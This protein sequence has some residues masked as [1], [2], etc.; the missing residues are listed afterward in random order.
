MALALGPS[1]EAA[2]S[3]SR[4]VDCRRTGII[5]HNGPDGS[6]SKTQHFSGGR[7]LKVLLAAL[8]ENQIFNHIETRH[9]VRLPKRMHTCVI[10]RNSTLEPDWSLNDSHHEAM[11]ST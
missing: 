8:R 7:V 6:C 5:L 3:Q 11:T 10:S 2:A 1:V 9:A 4:E